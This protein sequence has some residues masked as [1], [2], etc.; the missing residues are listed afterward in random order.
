M[1]ESVMPSLIR[2]LVFIAV[3]GGLVYGSLFALAE[4]VE[5]QQR[6]MSYKIPKED[7]RP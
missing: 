6:E 4:F 5:P 1:R 7:L 2:L 3:V